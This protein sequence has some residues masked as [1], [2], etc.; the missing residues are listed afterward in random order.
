MRGGSQLSVAGE[1]VKILEPFINAGTTLYA[2]NQQ[3]KSNERM[4]A[5]NLK[6]AYLTRSDD[7]NAQRRAEAFN[8]EQFAYKKNADAYDRSRQSRLDT[9]AA[10]LQRANN[11]MALK[12]FLIGAYNE[13]ARRVLR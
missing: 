8:R 10:A 9:Q 11:S 1:V 5:D 12:Q 4:N 7:L 6:L 2:G 13:R 3:R